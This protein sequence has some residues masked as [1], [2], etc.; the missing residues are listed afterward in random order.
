MKRYWLQLGVIGLLVFFAALVVRMPAAWAFHWARESLP[1]GPAWEDVSGG[2]FHARLY[3]VSLVLPGGY[4]IRLDTVE[5]RPRITGLFLGSLSFNY[6]LQVDNGDMSGRSRFGM[7]S[8]RLSALDGRMPLSNLETVFPRLQIAGLR[9]RLLFRGEELSAVYGRLPHA[10]HLDM[11]IENL[12]SELVTMPDSLGDYSIR[13]RAVTDEGIR[14]RVETL[15]KDA[16]LRI[17]GDVRI[18]PDS[19]QLVFKGRAA[20]RVDASRSLRPILAFIPGKTE[21]ND[22]EIDWRLDF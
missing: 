18:D 6:R 8:W 3:G 11:R 19:R 15:A 7:N 1:L 2:L 5:L 22:A 12:R 21:G 16:L 13:L 20:P 17:E 10:G 9:G 4:D 14:G